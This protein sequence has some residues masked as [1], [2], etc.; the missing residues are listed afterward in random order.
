[1]A[2]K[3][4]IIAIT[5]ITASALVMLGSHYSKEKQMKPLV[6]MG[7]QIELLAPEA[8]P[9]PEYRYIRGNSTQLSYIADMKVPLTLPNGVFLS[10]VR[11]FDGFYPL[12]GQMEVEGRSIS[13]IFIV[14]ESKQLHGVAV[15]QLFLDKT[16]M[17]IDDRFS[18][19]GRNYELR[20][21]I[22]SL[23]D[24]S[25]KQMNE[26]PLLM[27]RDY[28]ERG[29]GMWEIATKRG[30]R[31]RMISKRLAPRQLQLDFS[32]RFPKSTT[33]IKLADAEKQAP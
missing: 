13:D 16:G 9:E 33:V 8:V 17:K 18:M 4:S 5:V 2:S 1:M 26:E 22:K 29:N 25:G 12:Q 30:L 6:A 27:L 31:Y 24:D 28:A 10:N 21:V 3:K 14:D 23:P 11:G 19:N 15:N 32:M 20:G 7:G